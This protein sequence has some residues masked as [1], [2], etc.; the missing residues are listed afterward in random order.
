LAG[1]GLENML[2]FF[3]TYLTLFIVILVSIIVILCIIAVINKNRINAH[4][5]SIFKSYEDFLSLYYRDRY[6]SKRDLNIWIQQW[7]RIKSV[8]LT[9]LRYN[10]IFKGIISK[11]GPLESLILG[12]KDYLFLSDEY[13]EKVKYISNVFQDRLEIIQERNDEYVEKE[14]IEY[15]D[16]FDSIFSEPLTLQQRKC[17]IVDEAHNLIVAGAGTGKTRTIVGKVGYL[18]KKGIVTPDEVLMLSFGRGARDEMAER[19]QSSL[20]RNID[21]FTFHS[22]GY[23]II[24]RASGVKPSISEVAEDRRVLAKRLNDFLE[25]FLEERIFDYYFL[26]L[27]NKYF[28]YYFKPVENVLDFKSEEEYEDYLQQFEIRSLQGEHVKSYEECMIANF[29]YLNGIEYEYEKDYIVYTATQ[30][31]RQYQPDFYLPDYGVWIEHYGVDRNWNTSQA[32][33]S[34]KYIEEIFWKRKIHLVNSTHLIETFSYERSEGILISNLRDKLSSIG[35]EYKPVPR[36]EIFRKIKSLGDVTLF[37]GLLAKFLNLFKSCQTTITELRIKAKKY[38]NWKR[39]CAF[40]D[41]FELLYED[42]ESALK[43]SGRIDFNDMIIQ[44]RGYVR[45]GDFTSRYKYILV[46]EFQDIS[47]SRYKFL[48]S[49]LDQDDECKLFCVG[50][51]WQSIYR[52]TGSDLTIMTD[53]TRHFSFNEILYLDETFRNNDSI[54]GFS[55]GFIMKNPSQYRKK[56]RARPVDYQGVSVVWYDDLNKAIQ[57]TLQEIDS[58]EADVV[59][60][61]VL[62]RYNLDFYKELDPSVFNALSNP[63][64]SNLDE[65]SSSQLDFEYFTIHRSKG[66]EADY[67]VLIGIRSGTYGFPCEIEDDPVLN[68]VLAQEDMYPNAEERR[69]FYVGL[70]RAKNKVFL[71]A[72]RNA[73]SPFISETLQDSENVTVIGKGPTKE[74]TRR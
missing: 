48:K 16:F 70:T 32:V 53:F 21:V 15:K 64:E 29:L 27:V 55:S 50:D 20:S 45:N 1:E 36:D 4:T 3:F 63:S 73:I 47:Q 19:I 38:V 39:Y 6:F 43:D 25:E 59:K 65:L 67:V 14:L 66:K 72:N 33:D 11:T 28:T 46:D 61:L 8:I 52:F 2:G 68:L 56:I 69:L 35:V 62:G 10:V 24:G 7:N 60:V 31:R 23:H 41:I 54:S 74:H 17:I 34:Q 30:D 18:L 42:Y 58:L 13:D 71:L 49:L 44:A 22:L 9:Y 26:D 51:D 12:Y 5:G 40:L 57:N 37:V